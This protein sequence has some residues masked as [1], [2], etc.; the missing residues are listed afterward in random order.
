PPSVEWYTPLC[1]SPFGRPSV[2]HTLSPLAGSKITEIAEVVD[3]PCVRGV[4]L[5]SEIANCSVA[6]QVRPASAE[7]Q[8]P[9]CAAHTITSLFVGCTA[10]APMKSC[11]NGP[12]MLV[13]VLPAS[14]D[15]RMPAP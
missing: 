9:L 2:A 12:T 15:F 13:H 1:E 8:T 14:V 4:P 7:R 11:S 3:T 5:S 6:A 10:I